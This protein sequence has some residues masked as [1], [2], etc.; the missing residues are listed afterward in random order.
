VLGEL[1]RL[2]R[3]EW[4]SG[5]TWLFPF[6]E[7]LFMAKEKPGDEP[8]GSRKKRERSSVFVAFDKATISCA[9]F[10]LKRTARPAE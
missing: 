9:G 4:W 1:Q 6:R 2:D 10:S 8:D 5:L 7:L 3:G